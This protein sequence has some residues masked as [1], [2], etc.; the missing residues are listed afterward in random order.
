MKATRG[1]SSPGYAYNL[2]NFMGTL[3]MLSSMFS[4]RWDRQFESGLLQ[5]RVCELSVPPETKD[6]CSELFAK[7]R[8]QN[9]AIWSSGALATLEDKARFAEPAP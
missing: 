6:P 7:S 1:Q 9:W 5:G 8:A 3:A 4:S 2:G